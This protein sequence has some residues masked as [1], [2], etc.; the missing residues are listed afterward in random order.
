[1]AIV[2]ALLLLLLLLFHSLSVQCSIHL[3][4][5]K[6]LP[7]PTWAKSASEGVIG[8]FPFVAQQFDAIPRNTTTTESHGTKQES[9]E[10]LHFVLYLMIC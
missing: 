6:L 2:K 10:V 5:K 9:E 7:L 3:C 8:I 4:N 1:M